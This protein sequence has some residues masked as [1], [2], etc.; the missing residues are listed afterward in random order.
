[1]STSQPPDL[2]GCGGLLLAVTAGLYGLWQLAFGHPG[3]GAWALA[4]GWLA[5]VLAA[6]SRELAELRR[7]TRSSP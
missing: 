4:S 1:M 3:V 5:T 6:K 2:S 7:T